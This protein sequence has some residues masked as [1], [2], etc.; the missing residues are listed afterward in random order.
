MGKGKGIF[1]PIVTMVHDFVFVKKGS[2]NLSLFLGRYHMAK[3]HAIYI[4]PKGFYDLLKERTKAK[5]IIQ[6]VYFLEDV[7]RNIYSL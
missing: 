7:I 4:D 1:F 5:D 3:Y 2:S 6:N